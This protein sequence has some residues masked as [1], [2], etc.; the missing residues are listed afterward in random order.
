MFDD[1]LG[2]M[3]EAL[4]PALPHELSQRVWVV[5]TCQETV[6][7]HILTSAFW[8]CLQSLGFL[9]NQCIKGKAALISMSQAVYGVAFSVPLI[10]AVLL[11]LVFALLLSSM[12]NSRVSPLLTIYWN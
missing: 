5:H 11:M 1:F 9:I 3:T 12:E 4:L 6:V 7:L 8:S 10:P 2:L